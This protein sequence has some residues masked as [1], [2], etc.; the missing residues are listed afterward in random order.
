MGP[1]PSLQNQKRKAGTGG[2][3]TKKRSLKSISIIKLTTKKKL[4]SLKKPFWRDGALGK[5]F[6]RF[7]FLKELHTFLWSSRNKNSNIII[8]IHKKKLVSIW[9]KVNNTIFQKNNLTKITNN[10]F[11]LNFRSKYGFKIVAPN[12]NVNSKN[13]NN[14]NNSRHSKNHQNLAVVVILQ[15]LLLLGQAVQEE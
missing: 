9:I 1:K 3:T 8:G 7:Q 15:I 5:G 10:L 11:H 6:I 12:I 14:S 13:K 4:S 2:K